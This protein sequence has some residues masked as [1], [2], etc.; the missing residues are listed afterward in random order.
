MKLIG[1][2]FCGVFVIACEKHGLYTEAGKRID[3]GSAFFSQGIGKRGVSRKLTV[4][5]HISDRAA[6]AQM[7]F[8]V[9]RRYHSYT[10]LG[11]QLGIPRKD[12]FAVHRSADTASGDHSEI[13]CF[14]QCFSGFPVTANDRFSERMLRELL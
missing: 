12:G 9:L 3:S 2:S 10:I 8:R 6:A 14:R 4:C 5:C 7:I 11:K 13:G 1:N